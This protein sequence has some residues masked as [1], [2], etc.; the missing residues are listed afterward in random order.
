MV[1]NVLV[2]KWSF[3][4]KHPNLLSEH[5]VFCLQIGVGFFRAEDR[6][7][8]QKMT[9][10]CK[11]W[12][13]VELLP[14]SLGAPPKTL[15]FGLGIL[16]CIWWFLR[17]SGFKHTLQNNGKRCQRTPKINEH[18]TIAYKTGSFF[19]CT[20]HGKKL[21]TPLISWKDGR[22]LAISGLSTRTT[23]R[24]Y[25]TWSNDGLLRTAFCWPWYMNTQ[26]KLRFRSDLRLM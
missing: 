25:W 12:E 16:C 7:W 21:L 13:E 15:V 17:L 10:D 26:A 5:H 19:L 11:F 14:R 6:K 20:A 22:R 24:S 4:K 3:L 1:E 9:W 23:L 18:E 8:G 2:I